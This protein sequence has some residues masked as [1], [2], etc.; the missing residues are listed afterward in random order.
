MISYLILV[1]N[2]IVL[3]KTPVI[4]R[5]AQFCR[6]RTEKAGKPALSGSPATSQKICFRPFKA[7]PKMLRLFSLMQ[8]QV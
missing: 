1:C 8:K 5:F 7:S 3:V 4:F 2:G 6:A